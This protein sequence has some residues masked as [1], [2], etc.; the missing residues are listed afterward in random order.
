MKATPGEFTQREHDIRAAQQQA[1]TLPRR[2][3]KE[4]ERM[5]A[6]EFKRKHAT[7]K[8]G[9][10]ARSKATAE[11]AKAVFVTALVAA[12]LPE[13]V[14]EY[15]F[16]PKR[17]SLFDLAWPAVKIAVEIEGGVW[18]EGRHTGGAGYLVDI[19]KYNRATV[20]GWRLIRVPMGDVRMKRGVIPALGVV[21][22]AYAK[23]AGISNEKGI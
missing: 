10:S 9:G 23:L 20:Q 19:E 11:T 4:P 6:K 1:K 12:G 2:S 15:R 22:D 14:M 8:R 18:V 7:K 17:R 5:T 16:D 13:P 3:S 21:V